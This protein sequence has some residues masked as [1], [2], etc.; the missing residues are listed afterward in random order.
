MLKSELSSVRGR[1]GG[2]T[3][4]VAMLYRYEVGGQTFES[5]RYAFQATRSSDSQWA[6]DAV[7]QNPVGATVPIYYDPKQPQLSVMRRGLDGGDIFTLMFLTP[8]HMVGLALVLAVGAPIF[9]IFRK[10][11]DA[12]RSEP[13]GRE[14]IFV[15][16]WRPL[17]AFLAVFGFGSFIGIFLVAVPFGFHPPLWYPLTV[18]GAAMVWALWVGLSTRRKIREGEC[19]IVLDR[20]AALLSVPAM[21][22][23]GEREEIRFADVAKVEAR[24]VYEVP[25]SRFNRKSRKLIEVI[26]RT[27]SGGELLLKKPWSIQEGE[28]WAQWLQGKMTG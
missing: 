13:G 15:G 22:G 19:D 3:H 8:F 25:N 6:R 11:A 2:F 7:A 21:H 1:K 24:E 17:G 23:R 4:G 5:D 20:H 9:G 28:R 18:W 10:Q 26:V 12:G 27:K 16:E 14:R